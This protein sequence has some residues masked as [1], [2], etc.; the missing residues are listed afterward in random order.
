MEKYEDEP[1]EGNI[2]PSLTFKNFYKKQAYKS[3]QFDILI[4]EEKKKFGDLI[5]A[6]IG[7]LKK[8]QNEFSNQVQKIAYQSVLKK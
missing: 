3:H 2:H 4:N 8:I 6:I 5:K 1:H 7:K